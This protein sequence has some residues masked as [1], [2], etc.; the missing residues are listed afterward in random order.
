M[1]YLVNGIL[2][3]SRGLIAEIIA[4]EYTTGEQAGG[5]LHDVGANIFLGERHNPGIVAREILARAQN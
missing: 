3:G 5:S 2:V 4:L 1:T